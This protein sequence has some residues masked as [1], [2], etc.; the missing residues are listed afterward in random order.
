MTFKRGD[1]VMVVKPAP[2]CGYCHSLGRVFTVQ[3]GTADEG[4]CKFCG[5]RVHPSNMTILDVG[6]P[7]QSSRLR[8]IPPL[9]EPE[10]IDTDVPCEVLT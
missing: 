4:E 7:I 1:L 5:A 10:A 8:L 6:G 2:C 9:D 3:G